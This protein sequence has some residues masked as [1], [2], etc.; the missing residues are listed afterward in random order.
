MCDK[1]GLAIASFPRRI[2][3]SLRQSFGCGAQDKTTFGLCS[4]LL[5]HGNRIGKGLQW[6]TGGLPYL[7]QER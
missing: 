6:V 5:F 3:N 7:Q 1:I 4:V 2:G